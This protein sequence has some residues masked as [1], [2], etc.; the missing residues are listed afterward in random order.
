MML[1]LGAAGDVGG[2]N[3]YPSGGD[4]D[5]DGSVGVVGGASGGAGSARRS[6]G[7]VSSR[8]RGADGYGVSASGATYSAIRAAR[9]ASCAT[10]IEFLLVNGVFVGLG[11]AL[12]A[13]FAFSRYS[14]DVDQ[15]LQ[16]AIRG[17]IGSGC[18]ARGAFPYLDGVNRAIRDAMTNLFGTLG[19]S[20]VASRGASG[21]VSRSFLVDGRKGGGS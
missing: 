10:R 4:L 15:A 19:S 20:L 11:R 17:A 21:V 7:S 1:G 2:A 14:S 13:P 12:A 18:A 9:G 6:P 3:H 16:G 5:M 8:S